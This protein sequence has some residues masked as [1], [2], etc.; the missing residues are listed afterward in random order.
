MGVGRP[1]RDGGLG[2]RMVL[3]VWVKYGK[4]RNDNGVGLFRKRSDDHRTTGAIS[5]G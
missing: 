3:V 1:C 5:L 4:R 2:D